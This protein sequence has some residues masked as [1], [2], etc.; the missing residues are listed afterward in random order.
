MLICG[1]DDAKL[2]LVGD[3]ARGGGDEENIRSSRPKF[4]RGTSIISQPE[5]DE[6]GR[7]YCYPCDP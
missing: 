7:Y 6:N 2:A 4:G 1:G 3:N 5:Y